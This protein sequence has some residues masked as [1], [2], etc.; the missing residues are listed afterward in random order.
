MCHYALE[1]ARNQS[2]CLLIDY[3]TLTVVSEHRVHYGY[4][5]V[6]MAEGRRGDRLTPLG[7]F[8]AIRP[9]ASGSRQIGGERFYYDVS[10]DTPY[11]NRVRS[12]TL[13][14]IF[15]RDNHEAPNWRTAGSPVVYGASDLLSNLNSNS[16][17]ILMNSSDR[18]SVTSSCSSS[19]TE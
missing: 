17:Y 11:I 8:Q 4:N 5:G 14:P 6:A 15:Y 19:E 2:K 3:H 12:R 18:L 10:G 1:S 13:G 7:V 9:R 16:S